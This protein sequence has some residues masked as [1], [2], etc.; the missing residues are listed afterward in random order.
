MNTTENKS[1]EQ[2]LERWYVLTQIL[3]ESE[4][5]TE[6][7]CAMTQR[8]ELAAVLMEREAWA[9]TNWEGWK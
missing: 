7:D 8:S 4:D 3:A 2:L 6:L 9:N 5:E 1:T